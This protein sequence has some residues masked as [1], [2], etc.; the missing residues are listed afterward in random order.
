MSDIAMKER[1]IGERFIVDGH[2]YEV[3]TE[4]N[5][6][7]GSCNGC[8]AKLDGWHTFSERAR[9]CNKFKKIGGNCFSYHRTDGVGVIFK[10]V[11]RKEE[12]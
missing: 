8:G 5:S 10:E 6:P 7:W 12:E 1:K 2:L 3:A 4:N 9:R 11:K